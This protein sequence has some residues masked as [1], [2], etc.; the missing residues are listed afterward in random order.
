VIDSVFKDLMRHQLANWEVVRLG[1]T[2]IPGRSD[3]LTAGCVTSFAMARLEMVDSASPLLT[4]IV[5]LATEPALSTGEILAM[6]ERICDGTRP[7]QALGLR[8]WRWGLLVEILKEPEESPMYGLIRLDEFVLS[9]NSIGLAP[10]LPGFSDAPTS[11][12]MSP[13]GYLQRQ[14]ELRSWLKIEG[15]ELQQTHEFIWSSDIA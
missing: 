7:D 8:C 6:V 12:Y 10:P 5:A 1:L 13:R 9:W 15:D 3:F 2:D 11:E 4:Q 14:D